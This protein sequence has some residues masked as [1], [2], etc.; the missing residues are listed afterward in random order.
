MKAESSKRSGLDAGGLNFVRIRIFAGQ[1]GETTERRSRLDHGS[2]TPVGFYLIAIR[3]KQVLNDGLP[4]DRP[5]DGSLTVQ[6]IREHSR[7]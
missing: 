4:A 2:G 3:Q 5:V 7:W 1:V 6:S